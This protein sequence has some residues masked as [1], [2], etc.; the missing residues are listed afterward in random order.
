RSYTQ[1]TIEQDV[2]DFES[3]KSSIDE[4]RWEIVEQGENSLIVNPRFDF[5]FSL[6]IDDKVQIDYSDQKAIVSG[7]WYYAHNMV[8]DIDGRPSFWTKKAAKIVGL[9]IIIILL[10]IPVFDELGMPWKI[11]ENRHK[12]FIENIQV[13]EIDSGDSPG[14]SVQNIN[15]QGQGVEN[16]DYIFYVERDLNLARTN[17]DYTNKIYLIEKSQGSN[18]SRI[19]LAGDWIFYTSGKDLNRIRIDGTNNQTIYKSGYALDIHYKDNYLYFIN[20][21]DS[22]NV[23]KIDINGRNLER[24]LNVDARDIALYD[25]KMIVSYRDDDNLNVVKSFSLDGLQESIELELLANNLVKWDGY[26]YFIGEDYKL[27][28]NKANGVT[29]PQ[30]LVDK[31]VSSFVITDAGIFYS[32]HAE[33]VGYPGEDIF[34]VDLDGS[35]NTLVLE[36]KRVGGFTEVGDYVIFHSSNIDHESETKRL[37]IFTNEI[38]HIRKDASIKESHTP[39]I[40]NNISIDYSGIKEFLKDLS[41]EEISSLFSNIANEIYADDNYEDNLDSILQNS[42]MKHGIDISNSIDDVKS[43]LVINVKNME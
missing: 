17:K 18:I 20:L 4:R 23:Y 37:N 24:V 33:D 30:L 14:N 12:S 1:K 35:G 3:L 42:F 13:I 38:D 36:T 31:E 29:A 5:P 43:G 32:L 15:N 21:A 27:Y 10:S 22:H 34:K 25:N 41:Q 19:N 7:P 11:K 28:K 16:E 39:V 2:K 6:L 9:I 8:R 40:N 26:Y